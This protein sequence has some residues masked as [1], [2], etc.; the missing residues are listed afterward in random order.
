MGTRGVSADELERLRISV[1]TAVE[2]S[3]L[4]AVAEA[5][6]MSPSGLTKFLDGAQP[7]G[8]TVER[9]R[10]WHLERTEKGDGISAPLRKLLET[11]PE[12]DREDALSE[13][14]DA[15]REVYRR[16]GQAPPAWMAGADKGE[17]GDGA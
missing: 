15:A 5:V 7:Y 3:S 13:L 9:L 8:K 14:L 12:A 1:E 2:R 17:A 16:R 10:R 6:G 11:L 4:R